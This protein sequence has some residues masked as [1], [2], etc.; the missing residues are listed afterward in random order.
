MTK[1]KMRLSWNQR[2][3]LVLL[4]HGQVPAGQRLRRQGYDCSGA[5]QRPECE[6]ADDTLHHR[7]FVCPIGGEQRMQHGTHGRHGEAEPFPLR[8]GTAMRGWAVRPDLAAWWP[9]Q[10]MKEEFQ[11]CCTI[12]GAEV[13]EITFDPTCDIF[14]DGSCMHGSHPELASAGFGLVQADRAGR[15]RAVSTPLPRWMPQSAAWAEKVAS[16]YARMLLPKSVPYTGRHRGYCRAT[17][18]VFRNPSGRDAGA[19]VAWGGLGK[20]ARANGAREACDATWIRAHVDLASVADPIVRAEHEMNHEADRLTA[21]AA[22]A[23]APPT[24]AA[25]WFVAELGS[26]VNW[27]KTAMSIL[28]AWE[29]A[30][31][32]RAKSRGQ[33][34]ARQPLGPQHAWVG[35]TRGDTWCAKCLR[36][37]R[38][39]GTRDRGGCSEAPEVVRAAARAELEHSITAANIEGSD[40]VL[41]HCTK[42]RWLSSV[43]VA[44]TRPNVPPTRPCRPASEEGH[45]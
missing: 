44:A 23:A 7:L 18:S 19:D 16:M 30:R 41:A 15:Q 10:D 43:V 35:D 21:T 3:L 28:D 17:L 37:K 36:H 4:G 25:E 27:L 33:Q 45:R 6:G 11:L 1:G 39:V 24:A 31:A 32:V 26:Q 13:A 22:R 34:R 8:R 2:R 9:E 12:D 29:P 14:G 5:C 20:A 38:E 40:A 42:M